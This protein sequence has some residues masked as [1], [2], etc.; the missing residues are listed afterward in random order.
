M[1]EHEIEEMWRKQHGMSKGSKN[2]FR[3]TIVNPAESNLTGRIPNVVGHSLNDGFQL[4]NNH[5]TDKVLRGLPTKE[6]LVIEI[7][8][9]QGKK[10]TWHITLEIKRGKWKGGRV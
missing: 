2:Q 9:E 6:P 4:A 1:G 7:E 5:I 3:V 8:E 10:R